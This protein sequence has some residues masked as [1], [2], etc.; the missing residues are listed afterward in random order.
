MQNNKLILFIS[1]KQGS[2]KSTLAKNSRQAALSCG[3]KSEAYYFAEPLYRFQ[4]V[5]A[6]WAFDVLGAVPEHFLSNHLGS[7]YKNGPLLQKLGDAVRAGFGDDILIQAVVEKI[8]SF[9]EYYSPEGGVAIIE[10]ARL[11]LEFELVEKMA[12]D[13]GYAFVSILLE[14]PEEV[15]K[16]RLGDKWRPDTGHVTETGL[17]TP[18]WRK[19]FTHVLDT[20]VGKDI[21]GWLKDEY[22]QPIAP[23][24]STTFQ[25]LVDEFNTS[26]RIAEAMTMHGANFSWGYNKNGRKE[27]KLGDVAAISVLPAEEVAKALDQVPPIILQAEKDMGL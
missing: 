6:K 12:Q 23:A 13:G 5:V 24:T 2:G 8:T 27:L 10:D 22:F 3:L 9:L 16:E 19:R 4:D 11:P 20:S 26:L 17:F 21:H 7:R 14:C 18:E 15:R 1:G 25:R